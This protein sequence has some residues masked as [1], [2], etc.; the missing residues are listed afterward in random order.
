MTNLE[1]I[2]ALLF[3]SGDEGIT[4]DQLVRATGFMRPA[5]HDLLETLSQKYAVNPDSA[6][7]VLISEDHYRLATKAELSDLVKKYFETPLSTSLSPASLEVLAIVAYQQ[8]ITRIEIDEIRGVQSSSTVQKLVL[9][10]LIDASG[11][12]DEPGRPKVYQTTPTFL[13]YFGLKSIDELPPLPDQSEPA[14]ADSSEL[15]LTAFNQQLESS[16]EDEELGEE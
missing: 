5:V 10:R 6:I 3:I 15:F 4:L 2:E 1:Q 8:P 11:R 16:S 14:E 7:E 12:L 9:R 13:D